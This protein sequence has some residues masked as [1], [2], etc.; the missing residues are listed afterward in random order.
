MA[1]GRTWSRDEL[2]V[3]MNLYCKLPFGQLHQRNPV[4]IA[5]AEKL[6]RTP[7]SVA[8]KLCNLASLD[9]VQQARGISGLSGASAGD[10]AVWEEFN[11]DWERLAFESEKLLAKLDGKPVEA[12]AEIRED[13]LPREGLE[14]E[15][16]VRQRVN[17]RFFRAAVLAAYGGRC[18]IT[19][20]GVQDLLI[21][22]HIV[23]WAKDMANRVN[24]RNGLCLNALHDCA[25]DRGFIT[26]NGKLK[27]EVSPLLRAAPVEPVTKR[28]LLDYEGADIRLPE[29]FLPDADLLDWHRGNVFRQS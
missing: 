20:L 5:L 12:E 1:K 7:G 17:Q 4:I 22:S 9:P 28:L 25:F 3:A 16:V 24:P 21:A 6:G 11:K 27:V 2:V 8:M 10:R 14:R 26:L 23:P 15:R 18:C 19:S 13:E 29:R